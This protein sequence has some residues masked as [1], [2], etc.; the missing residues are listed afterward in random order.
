MFSVGD[1]FLFWEVVWWFWGGGVDVV[2]LVLNVVVVDLF[3]EEGV[4][5]DVEE[6]E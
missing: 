6:D 3:F 2:E 4:G 5:G 1:G